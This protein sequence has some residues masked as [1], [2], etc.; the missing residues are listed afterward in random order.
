MV[1]AIEEVQM[2]GRTQAIVFERGSRVLEYWLIHAEGFTV[3]S[4]GRGGARVETVVVDPYTG[5]ASALLVRSGLRR[6]LVEADAFSAV[7]PSRRTLSVTTKQQTRFHAG[8]LAAALRVA[9]ARTRR[10]AAPLVAAG[11][12]ELGAWLG[13]L[14][15]R[16]WPA[17]R[18]VAQRTRVL[19][20]RAAAAAAVLLRRLLLWLRPRLW[21]A[22]R[23]AVRRVRAVAV[24]AAEAG[25]WLQPRMRTCAHIATVAARK[26][27]LAAGDASCRLSEHLREHTRRRTALAFAQSP[28]RPQQAQ[29]QRPHPPIPAHA[30]RRQRSDKRD[31][32]NRPQVRP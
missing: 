8:A 14:R 29:P 11:A 31:G 19:T 10:R 15:P 17:T 21:Q 1:R 18:F 25:W 20:A 28:P 13:W 6:R 5:R 27:A 26:L 24:G 16:L 12:A 7:D 4:R 23:F 9:A 22:T 3:T 30:A 2:Q 32:R